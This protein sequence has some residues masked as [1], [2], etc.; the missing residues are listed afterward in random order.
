MPLPYLLY[1][2]YLNKVECFESI[3]LSFVCASHYKHI[4]STGRQFV[5]IMNEEES[6]W[7][8][9]WCHIVTR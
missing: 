1:L 2:I 7:N 8:F 6:F 9:F 5:V 3:W 4:Y